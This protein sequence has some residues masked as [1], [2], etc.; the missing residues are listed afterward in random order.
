MILVLGRTHC[1]LPTKRVT[2]DTESVGGAQATK[3][4]F[5]RK[6]NHKL[7]CWKPYLLSVRGRPYIT[8]GGGVSPN[9]YR[10]HRGGLTK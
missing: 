4:T 5:F 6:G 2:D 10:L 8:D 9:D 1:L 7:H 3:K